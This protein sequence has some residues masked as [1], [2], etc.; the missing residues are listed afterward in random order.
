VVICNG[1]VF[2]MSE[3]EPPR[4]RMYS[5]QLAFFRGNFVFPDL[6]GCEVSRLSIFY[7]LRR[8][9]LNRNSVNDRP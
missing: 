2:D 1:L 9:K 4:N 6:A 5:L 3:I 8:R 7:I